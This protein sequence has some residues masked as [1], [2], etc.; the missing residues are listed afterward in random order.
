M[1]MSAI[2]LHGPDSTACEFLVQ[3]SPVHLKPE[4]DT[5]AARLFRQLSPC[6]DTDPSSAKGLQA[7][8]KLEGVP[9]GCSLLDLQHNT[10][11][12]CASMCAHTISINVKH[13]KGFCNARLH[14]LP[15]LL[16]QPCIAKGPTHQHL[17]ST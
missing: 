6:V 4:T 5:D 8:H 11:D 16:R 13:N 3:E 7:L 17:K 2:V 1:L 15:P 9:F 14:A 12:V 10:A